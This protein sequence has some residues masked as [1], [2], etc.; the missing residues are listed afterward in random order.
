M[1]LLT[2]SSLTPLACALAIAITSGIHAQQTAPA[3]TATNY[4]TPQATNTAIN[5]RDRGS[6]TMTPMNQPNDKADIKLAALVRR[7]IVKDKSLS[8][9]AHNVKSI[10]VDGVVTLRGPVA[11]VDEKAKVESDVRAVSGV[12]RVENQLDVKTP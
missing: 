12:S 6:Q 8:M 11:S 1:R 4:A 3:N 10:V 5:R 7:T 9:F 2:K